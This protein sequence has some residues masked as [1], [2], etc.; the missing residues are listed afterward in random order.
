MKIRKKL[1]VTFIS[2]AVLP[3]LLCGLFL[4]GKLREIVIENAFVQVSTNVER[5]SEET[6]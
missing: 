2:V 5:V 3:L 6:K 4:T 1:A